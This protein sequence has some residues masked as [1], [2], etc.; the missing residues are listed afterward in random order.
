MVSLKRITRVNLFSTIVKAG[1]P[2]MPTPLT[3]VETAAKVPLLMPTIETARLR[4]RSHQLDDLAPYAAMWADPIVTRFLGGKPLSEE[5]AWSRILRH[6][7]HW[8]L[9]GFGYWLVEEK[10]TG[11]FLGEAGLAELHRDIV[12]SIVG[13]PE[14]GWVFTLG[15]QGQGYASEAM[16]AILAWASQTLPSKR[17]VCIIDPENTAS[18][19]LAMRLGYK[20]EVRTMFRGQPT[21]ILGREG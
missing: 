5:E 7:G 19:R 9:L 14:A 4:L 12:P 8:S 17:T 13:T 20:E 18:L 6:A 21:I 16:H 2:V 3:V 10:A 15:S 1:D 11:R